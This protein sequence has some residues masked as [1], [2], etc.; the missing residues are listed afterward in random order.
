MMALSCFIFLLFLPAMG[1]AVVG[2]R[3]ELIS[4]KIVALQ[5]DQK[6]KLDNNVAYRPSHP[7]LKV[8]MK[9]GD[10]VTLRYYTEINGQRVYL[11]Y[12]PGANSL[13]PQKLLQTSGKTIPK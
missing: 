3:T 4:G 13:T 5:S 2:V 9:V 1:M 7:G 10:V 6:I 12:A 8:N 11:E